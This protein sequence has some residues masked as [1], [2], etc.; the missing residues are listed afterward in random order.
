DDVDSG[1]RLFGDDVGNV[2]LEFLLVGGPAPRVILARIEQA[3]GPDQAPDMGR[4]DAVFAALH[5]RDL[6]SVSFCICVLRLLRY[7]IM[8]TSQLASLSD[9]TAVCCPL[10]AAQSMVKLVGNVGAKPPNKVER[11]QHDLRAIGCVDEGGRE[12]RESRRI[13]ISHLRDWAARRHYP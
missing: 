3:F 8:L 11:Q 9:S 4:Q 2:T 5:S 12:R 7:A 10:N 1:C 13:R 6:P